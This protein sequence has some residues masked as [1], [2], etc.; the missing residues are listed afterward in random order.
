MAGEEL[1][2]LRLKND[3]Y[4]DGFYKI[5]IAFAF[6]IMAIISL[7]TLSSYLYLAKP[8]PVTFSADNEWRILPPVALDQKYISTPDLI[9]WVSEVIPNVFTY[10]FVNYT[11]QLKDAAHYFTSNGWQKFLDQLNQ[12]ANFK[13]VQDSKLFINTNAG[14][15]PFILNQGM[16]NGKYS[17]WVQMPIALNYITATGGSVLNLVVQA[18][19]VRVS[20]LNNLAGVGIENMIVT[21]SGG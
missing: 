6:I 16:L 13:T 10:D 19:V 15:A 9:Q 21:K 11:T 20:T 4:R 2:I 17:W 18:L 5:L 12:Y 8:A 7:I 3:F 1:H 14:G